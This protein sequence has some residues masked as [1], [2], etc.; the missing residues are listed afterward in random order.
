MLRC[1]ERCDNAF[2][3]F[4]PFFHQCYLCFFL[5]PAFAPASARVIFVRHHTYV[6]F[7]V[8]ILLC[9]GSYSTSH[10]VIVEGTN[11]QERYSRLFSFRLSHLL[12]THLSFFFPFPLG[13]SLLL[14][15]LIILLSFYFR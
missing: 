11:G 5:S 10:F 7:C 14:L 4:L 1:G 15:L 12:S 8:C 3:L 6:S 13:L 9:E 2:L